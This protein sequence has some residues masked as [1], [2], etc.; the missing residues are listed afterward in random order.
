M[1]V[2]VSRDTGGVA[3]DGRGE[4]HNHGDWSCRFDMTLV[5][6]GTNHHHHHHHHQHHQQQHPRHHHHHQKKHVNHLHHCAYKDNGE[7]RV[8]GISSV[9]ALMPS[10]LAKAVKVIMMMSLFGRVVDL[11]QS[12]TNAKD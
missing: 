10:L 7:G 4:H 1:V 9:E 3:D 5:V 8:D 12:N 2:T 11:G 6:C